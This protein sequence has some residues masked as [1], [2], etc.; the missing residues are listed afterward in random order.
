MRAV[1]GAIGIAFGKKESG[2]PESV[3]QDQRDSYVA[4]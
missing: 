4:E 3:K 2:L 1:L